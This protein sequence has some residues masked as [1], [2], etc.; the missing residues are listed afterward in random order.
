MPLP[1]ENTAAITIMQDLDGNLEFHASYLNDHGT[2]HTT[3]V[4]NP[5]NGMVD[6]VMTQMVAHEAAE[7]AAVSLSLPPEAVAALIRAI[8][9][10]LSVAVQQARIRKYN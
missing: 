4:S 1:E 6:I 9:G 5:E 10:G 2:G 7:C 8:S 3:I